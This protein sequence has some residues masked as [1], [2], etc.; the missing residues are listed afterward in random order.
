MTYRQVDAAPAR[1][2][3][4]DL[5]GGTAVPVEA[6]APPVEYRARVMALPEEERP[7]E[8]LGRLG[9]EA[10]RLDEL[11]AILFGTGTRERD[12]L[13][14]A[15][16]LLHD[17]EGLRGT[18][19]A[20]IPTLMATDGVGPARAS[21]VMAA[22]ELGRRVHMDP[23]AERPRI[24]S[25]EQIASVLHERMQFLE[26]EELHVLPLDMKNRLLAAPTMT[27]RGTVNSA[28]ARI[29][30]IFKLAVR[31]NAPKIAL[32]HN[33]PSGDPS[34]SP[35][36]VAMTR[37]VIEAGRTLDIEVLDHLIFGHGPTGWIS[38][39]RKKLAFEED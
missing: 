9:P 17:R 15:Q 8:R 4:D 35:D 6:P 12:V 16:Q 32:A 20:D 13:E 26:Y 7:R 1:M 37:L 33:H 24:T 14:V 3:A 36:D 39:R 19:A 10:L 34:P 18:A 27:Y 30:E 22:F 2:V 21:Q 31:L 28:G 38:L 23:G 11:L 25:P 29:S 5:V